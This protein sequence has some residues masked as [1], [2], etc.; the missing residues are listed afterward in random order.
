MLQKDENEDGG[1]QTRTHL[2]STST[3]AP[4]SGGLVPTY[5]HT[6]ASAHQNQQTTDTVC[7][8]RVYSPEV[9][10]R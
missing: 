3:L 1:M 7:T 10:K 4:S 2:D 8:M 6:S 9:G 5:H